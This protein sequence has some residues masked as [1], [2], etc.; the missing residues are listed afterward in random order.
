MRSFISPVSDLAAAAAVVVIPATT[1]RLTRMDLA[2][3]SPTHISRALSD[4]KSVREWSSTPPDFLRTIKTLLF[5][6]PL[7]LLSLFC[8]V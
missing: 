4:G 7:V 5:P 2:K 6:L 3:A 8:L 1:P